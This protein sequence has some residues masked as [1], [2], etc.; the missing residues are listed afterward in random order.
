M[1]DNINIPATK[2]LLICLQCREKAFHYILQ[3][4][5][6]RMSH[7]AGWKANE[8]PICNA[9]FR[10]CINPHSPTHLLSVSCS[11]FKNSS[12]Y[13]IVLFFCQNSFD[14]CFIL[15][16]SFREENTL[17]EIYYFIIKVRKKSV[18]QKMNNLISNKWWQIIKPDKCSLDLKTCLTC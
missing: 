6:M 4:S 9:A 10:F 18:Q 1:R 14:L 15:Y 5:F 16:Y 3:T 12:C 17:I 13:K 7:Q 11:F 8:H 2:C